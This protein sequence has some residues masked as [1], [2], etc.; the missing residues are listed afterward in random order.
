MVYLISLPV[1]LML[2]YCATQSDAQ[3]Q[4]DHGATGT[5][6]L[7]YFNPNG[8]PHIRFLVDDTEKYHLNPAIASLRE[9]EYNKAITDLIYLLDRFVNQPKGLA[10]MG[11]VAKLTKNPPLAVQYYEKAIRLY[12]QYALTRAQYGAF[13]VDIGN[14][15]SGIEKLKQAIEMDQKL[16]LAHAWLSKAYYQSGDIAL[17]RQAAEQATK[18]GYKGKIAEE[19]QQDKAKK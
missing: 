5:L 16:A 9:G 4:I 2:F 18:L 15:R 8:D 3:P 17:A 10:L 12:P 14:V 11:A 1:F 13:L 19:V 6:N 7:D